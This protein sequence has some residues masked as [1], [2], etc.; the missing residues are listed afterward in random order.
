MRAL[1]GALGENGRVIASLNAPKFCFIGELL[2]LP[3]SLSLLLPG[4]PCL[5]LS[6]ERSGLFFS[7]T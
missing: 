5:S 7:F 3:P 1:C 6:A 2:L 4:F